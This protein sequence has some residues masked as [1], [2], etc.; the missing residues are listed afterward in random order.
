MQTIPVVHA[1]RHWL[2]QL[3]I[4][5]PLERRQGLT[6]QIVLLILL[7]LTFGIVPVLVPNTSAEGQIP[8][9]LALA[10]SAGIHF[11]SLT[12]LRRGYFRIAG[13]ICTGSLVL[14]MGTLLLLV[15]L[16]GGGS[17]LL[18]LILCT[19]L[20]ALVVRGRVLAGL[21]GLSVLFIAATAV[22][23]EAGL[24]PVG[25]LPSSVSLTRDY[26]VLG[27]VVLVT[28]AL[29][30]RWF[31]SALRDALNESAA[32]TRELEAI[33]ATQ[34]VTIA[35]QTEE[36]RAALRSA[37]Q[38]EAE[39]T[40]TLSALRRSQATVRALGLPI[41]PV[42]PGV[43]I[44]PLIGTMDS[45][46]ARHFTESVLDAVGQRQTRQVL[47]DVTGVPLIDREVAQQLIQTA[48][49]V[50]LLGAQL[51]LI[52]VRPEVAQTLVALGVNLGSV[53][54]YPDLQSAIA[55]LIGPQRNVELVWA[56]TV[57]R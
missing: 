28:L 27:T 2:D 1:F 15:G 51:W 50:G 10:L 30:V 54:A 41:I 47:I 46:R 49:A 11:T 14:L 3:P 44:A 7:C 32:T 19:T 4:N 38:R 25:L 29:L 55:V 57:W 34:A 48:A 16:R 52:G 35:Q 6:L 9:L 56:E 40:S 5:D 12:L 43:V 23:E 21:I 13:L 24:P 17:I 42:L 37:E 20:G 36:L 18:L 53:P 39:L 31:S 8:M 33:R 26:A 45:E 22:F